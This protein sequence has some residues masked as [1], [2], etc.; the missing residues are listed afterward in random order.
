MSKLAVVLMSGGLDST[1]C[2]GLMVQEGY[3]VAG[4][5]LNYGQ[6]TQERELQAFKDVCDFYGIQRRLVI[7]TKHLQEI[8]GSSLTDTAIDVTEADLNSTAIP[9]SYVPFRNANILAMATSWAEVLQAD[10]LTVGAVQEDSSGYPDCREEFF[11]AF[12]RTIDTG[13][14]MKK[15]LRIL[16]PLLHLSKAQIVRTGQELA[17]PLHLSWSCYANSEVACGRCDSCALRLRGFEQAGCT[18][19]IP[20]ETTS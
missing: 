18:D 6:R 13:T 14:A 1:V 3:E 4:L 10:A 20:Y 11:D 19:I 12:Q 15:P 9:N 2:V 7:D 5:H 8:G 17:A 16:T